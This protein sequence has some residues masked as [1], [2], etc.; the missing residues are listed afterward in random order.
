MEILKNVQLLDDSY[1][2]EVSGGAGFGRAAGKE[3]AGKFFDT[4]YGWVVTGVAGTATVA[5][6]VLAT[7][8]L[9][10]TPK[11]AASI[12]SRGWFGKKAKAW[13]EDKLASYAPIPE[14]TAEDFVSNMGLFDAAGNSV[15]LPAGSHIGVNKS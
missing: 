11:A 10:K 7:I 8:F 13:G 12:A 5:L 6:S 4:W 3:A 9:P 15:D 1:L 2:A 14:K